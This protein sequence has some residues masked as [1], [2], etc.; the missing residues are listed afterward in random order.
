MRAIILCGLIFAGI[1]CFA[2]NSSPI[3][4]PPQTFDF[5]EPAM[6]GPGLYSVPFIPLISTPSMNL[7]EPR[8]QV[9][10]SNSTG[11]NIAGAQNST[12]LPQQASPFLIA[13]R[14]AG[15]TISYD[16]YPK[17]NSGESR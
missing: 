4:N 8:L 10:A 6:L 1:G 11:N 9:G 14:L 2:Q 13:P 12:A 3:A 17:A 7:S 15:A 5:A 16:L